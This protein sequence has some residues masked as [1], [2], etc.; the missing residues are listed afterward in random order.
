MASRVRL[1][2]TSQ[3]GDVLQNV[4]CIPFALHNNKDKLFSWWNIK[5]EF[6]SITAREKKLLHSLVVRQGILMYLLQMAGNYQYSKC[7]V[8]TLEIHKKMSQV[9]EIYH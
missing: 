1:I 2:V 4:S 6:G 9:V 8:H 7:C 3:F 5:G